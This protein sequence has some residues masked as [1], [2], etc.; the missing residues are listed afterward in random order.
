[1]G[2]STTPTILESDRIL[3]IGGTG[4]IGRHLT[5][6]CLNYSSFVTSLGL[7]DCV[8]RK[9]SIPGVEYLQV[10]IS[11]RDK[12]RLV[13]DGRPFDYVF[14][15]GGYID[16]V[17]YLKGGHRVLESHLIGVTNIIEC[18]DVK[19]LKGFV[20][21]GSSDEYGNQPAPQN[22]G[23]REH[24][25]STY[26]FSKTA[27]T[28]FIQMLYS[29]EGF[30]GVI[31]RLFLVYGPGQDEK[32]FLPQLVIACLKGETIETTDGKQ[33]RDFC[34]IEDVITGMIQAAIVPQ[35]NGKIINIASGNPISIK[36]I[37]NKVV[38]IVGKGKP[39]FGV[40]PYRKGEN[41][42]LYADISSGRNIL[43]WAPCITLQEGLFK[44]I[45]HYKSL[46]EEAKHL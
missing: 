1:M 10:D 26:S 15:L 2:L 9:M 46:L 39:L 33:L 30:P 18:L 38:E 14:N 35:A 7:T 37:I 16:H 43:G 19:S 22:E 27:A 45:K 4:F 25:F 21:V 32:R 20:Q 3:I 23:M 31:T 29:S 44:T 11:D 8:E 34:Y 24:P 5:Q 42:E 17:P 41:M 28:H 12:L 6:K 40:R 36:E 13:L